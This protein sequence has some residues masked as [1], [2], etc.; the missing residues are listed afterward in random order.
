LKLL[1]KFTEKNKFVYKFK[2]LTDLTD[3]F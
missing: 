1:T 3:E 2:L